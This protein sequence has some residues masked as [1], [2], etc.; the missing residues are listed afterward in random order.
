MQ[1]LSSTRTNESTTPNLKETTS[2][3]RSNKMQTRLMVRLDVAP[4]ALSSSHRLSDSEHKPIGCLTANTNRLAAQMS[5]GQSKE[6][7]KWTDATPGE[8]SE[9]NARA[10]SAL[11]ASTG[12]WNVTTTSHQGPF[13]RSR[14]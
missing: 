8:G 10:T 6:E 4:I 5:S 9:G 14:V 12:S 13:G 1:K 2:S 11:R 7:E 3:L